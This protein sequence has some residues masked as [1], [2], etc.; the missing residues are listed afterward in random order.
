MESIN[1]TAKQGERWDLIAFKMYG[2][3]SSMPEIIE[4]NPQVPLD[5]VLPD[6]TKLIIPI[7]EVSENTILSSDLPPWKR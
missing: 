7:L 5:P 4:A 2:N 1:Y 3:V 6:G